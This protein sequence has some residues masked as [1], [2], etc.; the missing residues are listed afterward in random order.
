[1]S[2]TKITATIAALLASSTIAAASDYTFVVDK[3]ELSTRAGVERTAK[4]IALT[5]KQTCDVDNVRGIASTRSAKACAA[6]VAEEILA[7][8]DHPELASVFRDSAVYA[9]R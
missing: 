1:M 3:S 9:S 7:E 2:F 6:D 5:A 8:I 4:R